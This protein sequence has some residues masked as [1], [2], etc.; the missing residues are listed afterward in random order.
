MQGTHTIFLVGARASGKTTVGK[1]LAAALG[2]AFVDTDH[3]LQA[4]EQCT[5]AHMVEQHGWDY[6]RRKEGEYLRRATSPR[7]VVA[8][9]GG[10]VLA[11]DNHR[12]MR[13]AG[14]VFYLSAPASLLAARLCAHPGHAQRPSLTGQALDQEVEEVLRQ[15]DPLYRE[16]AHHV[17]D[18]TLLP[19]EIA[20][21]A[22]A[23]LQERR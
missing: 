16:A 20:A 2:W 19:G 14:T 6:F 11:Q 18:A 4:Q 7:I 5:V 8:T 9:G 12:F 3:L 13:E 22:L 17:L 1:A 10:M 23:C 15:R 21:A